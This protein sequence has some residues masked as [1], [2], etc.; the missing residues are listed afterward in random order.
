MSQE[1][2]FEIVKLVSVAAASGGLTWFVNF[3]AKKKQQSNQ[4]AKEEFDSMDEIVENF[5]SRMSELSAK[6]SDLMNRNIDIEERMMK[7]HQEN[8]ALLR[9]NQALHEELKKLKMKWEK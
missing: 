5:T 8:R 3:K 1:I 4:I 2:I 9:E 7:L 6:L